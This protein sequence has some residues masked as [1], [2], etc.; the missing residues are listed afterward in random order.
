MIMRSPP[1]LWTKAGLLQLGELIKRSREEKGLTLRSLADYIEEN[2]GHEVGYSSL[3]RVERGEGST[4]WNTLAII[5]AAGFIL[6]EDGT[7]YTVEELSAIACAA[8]SQEIASESSD[9]F[10]PSYPEKSTDSRILSGK[11][12]GRK[13]V[14]Q[15]MYQFEYTVFMR[16]KVLMETSRNQLALSEVAYIRTASSNGITLEEASLFFEDVMD[17][18]HNRSHPRTRIEAFLPL[19]FRIKKPASGFSLD[20]D[21]TYSGDFEGL[22]R[23]L[24]QLG[25]GAQQQPVHYRH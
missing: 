16:L 24:E 18:T 15:A 12:S 5:A 23:D 8:A 25:N 7:P 19:L 14:S 4:T 17:G 22:V 11:K 20:V 21:R 13:A 9:F 1:K 6:H 3:G 2:T 10:K